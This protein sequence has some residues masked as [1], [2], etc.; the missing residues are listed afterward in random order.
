[1]CRFSHFSINNLNSSQVWD[2]FRVAKRA[3]VFIEKDNNNKII[4]FHD[5]Y[6]Y[7]N[8]YHKRTWRF[9]R[10]LIKVDDYLTGKVKKGTANYIVSE[11]LFPIINKKKV[12][13]FKKP[14][15]EIKVAVLKF[16]NTT[17]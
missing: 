14:N 1:M 4:A 9:K 5:G 16:K 6:R 13:F 12:I 7:I 10:K 3:K 17:S 15:R 8:T 11:N 2:S